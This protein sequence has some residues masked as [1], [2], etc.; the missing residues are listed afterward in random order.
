[1]TS[2]KTTPRQIRGGS[3][4]L[5]PFLLFFN[6]FLYL[7]FSFSPTS[8]FLRSPCRPPPRQ[9]G[10]TA[11]PRDPRPQ[12]TDEQVVQSISLHSPVLPLPFSSPP[13]SPFPI[14]T[15]QEER[16][17][18]SGVEPEK[19]NTLGI[20]LSVLARLSSPL[21]SPL[22]LPP[23][24]FFSKMRSTRTND[25]IRESKIDTSRSPYGGLCSRGSVPFSFCP[26]PF[27]LFSPTEGR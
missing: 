18:S 8:L 9:P 26:P 2:R 5:H 12:R 10:G 4:L 16:G 21:F 13:P 19:R 27:L 6:V 20:R 15:V 25:P 23:F 17:S 11:P 7:P 22:S 14:C 1:M 3:G 24:F